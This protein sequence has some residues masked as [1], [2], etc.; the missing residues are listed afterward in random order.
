M[1]AAQDSVVRAGVVQLHE[2]D[3]PAER[4]FQLGR[5][6]R[7]MEEA[8]IVGVCASLEDPQAVEASQA[9]HHCSSLRSKNSRS[10]LLPS[11]LRPRVLRE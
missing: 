5:P 7:F 6:K 11:Y 4:L 9:A 8:A 10:E 2:R 3:R 1:E